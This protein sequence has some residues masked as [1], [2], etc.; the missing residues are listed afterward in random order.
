MRY[1]DKRWIIGRTIVAVDLNPTAAGGDRPWKIHDPVF[2]LDNGAELV[3]VVE[4]GEYEYGV[5]PIVRNRPK[6]RRRT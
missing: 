6:G 1:F 4:E 2:T 3:F 5:T